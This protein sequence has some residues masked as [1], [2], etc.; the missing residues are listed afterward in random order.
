[1]T[2]IT[3]VSRR[4]LLEGVVQL[5]SCLQWIAV[6]GLTNRFLPALTGIYSSS[7]P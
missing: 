3:N 4:G 6:R 2:V 7:G 1:M 5:S